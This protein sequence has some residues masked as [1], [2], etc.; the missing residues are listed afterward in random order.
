M[1]QQVKALTVKPDNM[2]WSSR[3][4]WCNEKTNSHKLSSDSDIHTQAL[5]Q[6]VHVCMCVWGGGWVHPAHAYS[7]VK[8]SCCS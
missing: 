7:A 3:T 5:L 4:T 2:T 6:H 8:N 1:A